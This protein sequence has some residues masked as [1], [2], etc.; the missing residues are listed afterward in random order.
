MRAL[1]EALWIVVPIVAGSGVAFMGWLIKDSIRQR[2][3]SK[4]LAANLLHNTQLHRASKRQ[5]L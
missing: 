2:R 3:A 5:P 1:R 4:R